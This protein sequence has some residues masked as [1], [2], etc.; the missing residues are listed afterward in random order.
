MRTSCVARGA[1][2]PSGSDASLCSVSASLAPLIA[3]ARTRP[4][5]RLRSSWVPVADGKAS[6]RGSVERAL[7][8][9]VPNRCEAVALPFRWTAITLVALACVGCGS[10][11]Q[12]GP[13]SFFGEAQDT[14]VF[15]RWT[16]S[17][18]AVS[19]SLRAVRLRPGNGLE[20]TSRSFTGLILGN[21]VSLKLEAGRGAP[22]VLVGTVEGDGFV[23]PYPV[24]QR[25]LTTMTFKPASAAA[26]TAAEER[27][28]SF[29]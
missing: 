21:T 10:L 28:A 4:R 3:P 27:L 7:A 15:I 26:F 20:T 5:T 29:T 9:K 22:T 23:L 14:A 24:S 16:R 1:L 8:L 17:R 25:E 2:R 11:K 12:A 18:N 13:A 19:G 6:C